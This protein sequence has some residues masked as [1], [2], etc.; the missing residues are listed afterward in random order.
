MPVDDT[1]VGWKGLWRTSMP[2]RVMVFERLHMRDPQLVESSGSLR[3]MRVQKVSK[4]HPGSVH[5]SE[6]AAQEECV[7]L[8]M[9]VLKG[10]VVL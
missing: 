3:Y 1:M 2:F 5:P 4:S 7:A 6:A 9:E 10:D 8:Y